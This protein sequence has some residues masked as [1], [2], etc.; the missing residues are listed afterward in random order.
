MLN[1]V[2]DT[3]H[4]LR[5]LLRRTPPVP[6][7]ILVPGLA[8]LFVW[9]LLRVA[10]DDARGTFMAAFVIAMGL[11]FVMRADGLIRHS[12]S[13]MSGKATVIV[14]MLAG[15]GGMALAIWGAN[16]MW[17]QQFLSV[18]FLLIAALY[19]ID[20]IDGKHAL[21]QFHWPDPSMRP[22]DATLT[23]VMAIFNLAMVLL[24]E[25][26]ITHTSQNAWLLYFGLL[27]L[28]SHVV[29]AAIVRTVYA[30]KCDPVRVG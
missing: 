10:L 13:R 23:R 1:A 2:F 21:V 30:G 9:P 29:I 28:L 4:D 11:R 16:P 22:A 6:F 18:Y 3:L 25:T 15:P 19:V 20:V 5:D 17:C 12:R 8:I 7:A 27:P 26:L 24:N 14:A